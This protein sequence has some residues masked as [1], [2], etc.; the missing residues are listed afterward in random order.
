METRQRFSV[1]FKSQGGRMMKVSEKPAAVVAR[2][3]RKWRQIHF[4]QPGSELNH[5]FGPVLTAERI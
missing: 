2:E 3:L 4:S 1:E 5:H